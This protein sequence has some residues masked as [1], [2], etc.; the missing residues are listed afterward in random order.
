M[1]GTA[2]PNVIKEFS[3][4]SGKIKYS[5]KSVGQPANKLVD[6]RIVSWLSENYIMFGTPYEGLDLE[7]SLI[8]GKKR[9]STDR[10]PSQK[11]TRQTKNKIYLDWLSINK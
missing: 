11:T 6:N 10:L 3:W 2:S 7:P 4:L 8:E 9:I 5:L 1:A